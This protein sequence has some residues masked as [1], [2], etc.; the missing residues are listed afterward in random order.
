MAI[1]YCKKLPTVVD[2]G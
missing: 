1:F 2:C